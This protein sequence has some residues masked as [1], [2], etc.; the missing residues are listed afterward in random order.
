MSSVLNLR[1]LREVLV[2]D[3]EGRFTDDAREWLD[4]HLF[5][6]LTPKVKV[7]LDFSRCRLIDSPGV[8]LIL[9]VVLRL[10]EDHQGHVVLTALSPLMHDVLDM[11]GVL[12]L[13]H[14]APTADIGL[15]MACT[16]E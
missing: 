11:A 13:A 1:T 12:P 8:A 6:A 9:E 16:L 5:P 4:N 3:V 2:V 10:R 15:S 14:V 7:L